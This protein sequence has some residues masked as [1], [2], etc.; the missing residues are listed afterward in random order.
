VLSYASVGSAAIWNHFRGD[1]TVLVAQGLNVFR[2]PIPQELAG[3]TLAE[4]HVLR[5]T[6]CN[7]VAIESDGHIEANPDPYAPLPADAELVL[8]GT[9]IAMAEFFEAYPQERWRPRRG[10]APGRR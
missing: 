9:D 8:V 3:R 2:T 5:R 6:S 4:A 1:E 10:A 7:V